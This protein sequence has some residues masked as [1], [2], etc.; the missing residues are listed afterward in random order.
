V[1]AE[2][3]IQHAD[4][5]PKKVRRTQANQCTSQEQQ[6]VVEQNQPSCVALKALLSLMTA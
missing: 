5:L 1:T 3:A 4:A 2:V 6:A